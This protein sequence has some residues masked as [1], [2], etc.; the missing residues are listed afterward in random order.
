LKYK[1]LIA[2]AVGILYTV[3]SAFFFGSYF[4][5]VL[6]IIAGG[7]VAGFIVYIICAYYE[8]KAERKKEKREK[9][10]LEKTKAQKLA[11]RKEEK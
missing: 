10:E 5:R 2:V 11:L 4:L 3:L 8:D 9:E 6:N 7:A 1:L